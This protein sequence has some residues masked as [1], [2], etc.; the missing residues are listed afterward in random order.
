MNLRE[1]P[2]LMWRLKST[3]EENTCVSRQHPQSSWKGLKVIKWRLLKKVPIFLLITNDQEGYPRKDI[4]L[5]KLW[6]L[7]PEAVPSFIQQGHL[8]ENRVF[9]WAWATV[10]TFTVHIGYP[11]CTSSDIYQNR[12]QVSNYQGIFSIDMTSQRYRTVHKM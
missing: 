7:Q 9:F 8:P 3:E 4:Y 2:A 5:I 11:S 12:L 6:L 1:G 10:L